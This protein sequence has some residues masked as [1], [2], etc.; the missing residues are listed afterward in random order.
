MLCGP[1][2]LHLLMFALTTLGWAEAS[3]QIHARTA[4]MAAI[5]Y[6][7]NIVWQYL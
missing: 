7:E 5:V 4:S 2:R 6:Q 3:L 1:Y